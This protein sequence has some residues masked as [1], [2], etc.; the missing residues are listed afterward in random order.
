MFINSD[1]VVSYGSEANSNKT[2]EEPNISLAYED[3]SIKFE[4]NAV[5]Y[6]YGE[7]LVYQ[8]FLDGFD[9]Q[10]SSWTSET[11]K[12]YTNLPE[13]DY[14]FNIKAKNVFSN[15]STTAKYYFNIRTPWYRA[16]YAY[17]AYIAALALIIYLAV[18]LNSKRLEKEKRRY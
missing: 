10:P 7:Q 6:N 5:F 12:E 16:W 11:K 8:Y 14:C 1:S 13:G 9:N 2:K 15:E 17:F 4:Y 18:K 3:N